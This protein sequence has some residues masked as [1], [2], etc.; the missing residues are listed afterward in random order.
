MT[1]DEDVTSPI[2]IESGQRKEMSGKRKEMS[3]KRKEMSGQ[4]KEMSGQRKEMSGKPSKRGRH[5]PYTSRERTAE[6]DERKAF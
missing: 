4:R 2:P 1:G 6:R 5:Q 3:G